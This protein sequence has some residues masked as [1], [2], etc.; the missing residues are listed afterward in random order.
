MRENPEEDHPRSI[1]ELHEA[2]LGREVLQNDAAD[3]E[4]IFWRAVRLE[5]TAAEQPARADR[6]EAR[7]LSFRSFGE[8]RRS[9]EHANFGQAGLLDHH[10]GR[11]CGPGHRLLAGAASRSH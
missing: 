7:P 11:Y 3:I 6:S 1:S 4:E 2:D 10:P 8:G 9:V 5:S